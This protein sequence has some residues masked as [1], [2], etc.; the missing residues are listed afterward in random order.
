M[1]KKGYINVMEEVI[2]VFVNILMSGPEYQTFCHC[3]KC[4][5]DVIALS[6]NN[7]PPQYVTNEERR[8]DVLERYNQPEMRTWINK[9]IIQAM[10][11]VNKFP[12]H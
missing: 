7:I 12:K 2:T 6:L 4:K 10:H 5:L 11:V 9:R 8:H 3:S 1:D